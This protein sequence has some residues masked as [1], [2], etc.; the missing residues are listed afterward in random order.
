MIHEANVK[1]T[2]VFNVTPS[3]LNMYVIKVNIIIPDTND[4]N[5]PGQNNPSNPETAILVASIKRYVIGIP[6]NNKS[7]LY[8]FAQSQINGPLTCIQTIP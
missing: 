7:S 6:Q 3:P 8:F 2:A 4:K 1:D 5:L